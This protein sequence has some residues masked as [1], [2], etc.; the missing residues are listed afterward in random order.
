[1]PTLNG[2]SKLSA[3]SLSTFLRSP[4]AFYWRYV[5]KLDT[6]TQSTA[7][8]DE[9][10]L[11]GILWAEFVD[12]FYKGATED[13]N[14][15]LMLDKWMEQTNGWV[16]EKTSTKLIT[17]MESWSTEYYQRFAP[18]DGVRNGSEKFVENTRFLGYLDGLSPDEKILHEVKSTSRAPQLAEQLWK[19][20]HSLQVRLY[21]VLTRVEGVMIEIAY[22]DPPYGIYRAPVMQVKPEQIDTWERELNA[23]ADSIYALGDNIDNYPCHTDGCCI[24]SRGMVAM[25]PFTVLC[26]QGYDEMTKL[27]F[28]AKEHRKA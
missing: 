14:T 18:D 2:I 8:F 13:K 11:V 23:L 25:C 1:M 9:A 12:R 4:R 24:V 28:K 10:K 21:C 16:P 19:I 6:I 5:K 7:T 27:A 26:E 20:Q 17:A 3:S 15:D 22:K